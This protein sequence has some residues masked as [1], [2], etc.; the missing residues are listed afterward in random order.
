MEWNFRSGKA[1]IPRMIYPHVQVPKVGNFPMPG[2]DYSSDAQ[3]ALTWLTRLPLFRRKIQIE[4]L[5]ADDPFVNLMNIFTFHFTSNFF[6]S[7][8]VFSA[9]SWYNQLLSYQELF[10]RF[11]SDVPSISAL[12]LCLVICTWNGL[13]LPYVDIAFRIGCYI[14]FCTS[15]L[16]H[17][18]RSYSTYVF[19]DT[20][21][22][23]TPNIFPILENV[24]TPPRQRALSRYRS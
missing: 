21:A 4:F 17:V 20:N 14:D 8:W 23:R 10:S 13:C 3:H 24:L 11:R 6:P 18:F 22:V 12:R 7:L 16:C 2:I 5:F 19:R 9:F 1:V 15:F